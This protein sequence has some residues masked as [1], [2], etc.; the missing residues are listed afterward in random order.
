MSF[1]FKDIILPTGYAKKI[2]KL[3]EIHLVKARELSLQR[4]IIRRKS[5]LESLDKL[6]SPL[7][8]NIHEKSIAKI[9]LA[10]LCLGEASKYNPKTSASFY[11]GNSNPKIIVLFLRLLKLCFN[12]KLDKIR[13]TIQCRADQDI[14]ILENYWQKTTG[15]P[16]HL[17]YKTRVDPRTKGR[18]TKHLNYKGV[19]RV[20]YFDRK[21]Q[22]ELESL[23]N[24]IYNEI[25][26]N[27]LVA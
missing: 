24:L 20:D 6:N 21:V 5:F 18:P 15:I 3:N 17:F 27:G 11:L 14:N 1:W 8:K 13:C 22:L 9:A 23:A 10:M 12:F 26:F 16:K 4:Y 2:K 19:L 7:A 25:H